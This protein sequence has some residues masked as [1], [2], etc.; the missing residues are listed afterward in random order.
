M[1]I[2]PGRLSVNVRSDED[3]LANCSGKDCWL[4]L[5]NV[6]TYRQVPL[7]KSLSLF[8][9]RIY[10]QTIACSYGDVLPAVD[11]VTNWAIGDHAPERLFPKK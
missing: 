11:G 2:E 5:P 10:E 9:K 4:F 8:T 3:F 1:T 7:K 6:S